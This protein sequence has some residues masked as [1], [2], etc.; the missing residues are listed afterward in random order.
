MALTQSTIEY[1]VAELKHYEPM[2]L[3]M[4]LTNLR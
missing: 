3:Q 2:K 1:I 4:E